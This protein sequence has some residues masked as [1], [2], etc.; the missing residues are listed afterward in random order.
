MDMVDQGIAFIIMQ[1]GNSDLDKIYAD[2]F[3]PAIKSTGLDPKR[4]DQDNSGN[5]LK[6]EIVEYIEK[7][8][9]IIADIT[10]ERPNCYLEIG[11]AMG[12]DK[13][14]NLIFTVRE[15]HYHES[16]NYIKGGP[17]IHFDVSGY[18]I[19][20]WDPNN[21]DKFKTS[22]TDKINRRLA[23]ISPTSKA[24]KQQQP[25]WDETWLKEKRKYVAEIYE[26]S[27]FKRNME[28][29]ISPVSYNLNITQNELLDIT[30]ESQ[31]ETFGWPIGI[32]YKNVLELKPIAKSDGILSV[33]YGLETNKSLDYSYF[34]KNGQIYISKNLFED[35]SFPTSIIPDARV[36]RTTEIFLYILRFYSR[37]KLPVDERIEV[38]IK[39]SGLLNNTISFGTNGY[40]VRQKISS[41]NEWSLK[42]VT[43]LSDIEKRLTELVME[44][45]NG[46]LVLFD[47]FELDFGHI[48]SIV[49]DYVKNTN[50]ARR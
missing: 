39:Y 31:I 34:K 14:K 4:I 15:D 20:F 7:A 41:E 16:Q 22:L 8:E 47:F 40:P 27:S 11:Y 36:R 2:I 6:K 26:K 10:N 12:L 49:D 44:F 29:L 45:T 25:L 46:L 35:H 21:L 30:D 43:S 28:I 42:T 5:L 9:I 13:Y 48:N 3:V 37:C 17:K 19:L 23:T 1:I 33:V 32:V 18:D 50:K 38:E 24:L